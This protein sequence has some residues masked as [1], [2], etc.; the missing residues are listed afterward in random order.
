MATYGFFALN[1]PYALIIGIGAFGP[2]VGAFSRIYQQEKRAGVIRLLKKAICLDF[3][4]LWLIVAFILLALLIG[5]SFLLYIVL[6]GNEAVP[7]MPLRRQPWLIIPLFLF[8]ILALGAL[9]EEFGWRGYALER[10]AKRFNA[11]LSSLI[12]GAFWALWRLPLFFI[13]GTMQSSMPFAVFFINVLSISVLYTWLYNNT[14]KSLF[15][16]LIFHGMH[17][18]AY[19]IFPITLLS[20][21]TIAMLLLT[22]LQTIAAAIIIL[23]FGFKKL[24]RTAR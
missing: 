22:A 4:K 23:L 24:K 12:L 11:L 8:S 6:A 16:V 7:E 1:I 2:F 5:V 18:T 9:Q 13:E 14:N 3:D 10:I 20:S 15:V 17:N 19:N 21:P